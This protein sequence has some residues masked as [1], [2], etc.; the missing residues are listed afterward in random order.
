MQTVVSTD[1]QVL[2]GSHVGTEDQGKRETA[3]GLAH[4]LADTHT[5]YLKTHGFHWNVTGPMFYQLHLLFEEQ[6][7]E[8]FEASDEIAERI[9]ALGSPAPG[10][11]KELAKLTCLS[12]AEGL[13]SSAEMISQLM[14]DHEMVARTIRWVLSVA[15][16]TRDAAT[17]DV[18]IRH[19]SAH[20]RAAW[21][22]GS[23]MPEK[24][25]MTS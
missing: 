25:P 16:S 12:E 13:P 18:L 4:L 3:E 17:E 5:L 8:L 9:R 6:Y 11:Y 21:M 14:N 1:K 10:S 15:R 7:R 2:A 24:E 22:L 23:L 20:E 19:L